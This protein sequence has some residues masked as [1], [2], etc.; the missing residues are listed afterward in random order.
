[1]TFLESELYRD[2]GLVYPIR[3]MTSGEA[4]DCLHR[5]EAIEKARGGRLPPMMAL[6]PHLLIPWLWNLVHDD[7]VVGPVRKILG[8][9]ILCWASS[10]FNKS[11]G[12]A[13]YVPWHQDA[14]YWGLDRPN[15]VTAWIAFSP[16]TVESGC[17]RVVPGSHKM[18]LRHELAQD[19]N[20]MLYGQEKLVDGVEEKNSVN[21]ELAPGEMSL[22]HLLLVHGS[23]PNRSGKRRV[24]FAIRYIAGDLRQKSGIRGT[25]TLV[26]GSNHGTYEME[27]KPKGE[28]DP[29][30]MTR[31]RE[32]FRRWANNV[33]QEIKTYQDTATTA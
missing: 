26:A 31:H 10:F 13:K 6:K 24:G 14:T 2:T 7:R 28:F 16:S 19:A 4:E 23:A 9:D 5:L 25:A 20:N 8:P 12:E 1:M 29:D 18:L 22:H 15:A 27:L 21:V 32:I 30:A 11:P 17:L 33:N 3:V